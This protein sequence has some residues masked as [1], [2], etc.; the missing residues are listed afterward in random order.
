M[1]IKYEMILNK[2]IL[3]NENQ[4]DGNFTSEVNIY[5]IRQILENVPNI[6]IIDTRGFGDTKGLNYNSKIFNMIKDTFTNK[7]DSIT[8]ICFLKN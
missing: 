1:G 3:E 6:R 7:C 8:V 2:N 5:N 4:K